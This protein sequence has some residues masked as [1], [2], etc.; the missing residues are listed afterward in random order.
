MPVFHICQ[1]MLGCFFRQPMVMNH[2]TF[3]FQHFCLP[4][5]QACYLGDLKICSHLCYGFWGNVT[6]LKDE[7]VLKF[8]RVLI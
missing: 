8:C 1:L 3:T 4:P 2:A 5:K 7:N 6:M